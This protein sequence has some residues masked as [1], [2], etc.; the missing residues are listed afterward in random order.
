MIAQ[1]V[2]VVLTLDP[3]L[4]QQID[5]MISSK[6]TLLVFIQPYSTHNKGSN[7]QTCG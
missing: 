4:P 6:Q 1:W 7:D 2:N 5:F 3:R